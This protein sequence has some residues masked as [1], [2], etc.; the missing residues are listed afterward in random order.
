MRLYKALCALIETLT[1]E[2]QAR[3]DLER[4]ETMEYQFDT[5]DADDCD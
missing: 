5:P 1:E 3:A 4:L 2:T